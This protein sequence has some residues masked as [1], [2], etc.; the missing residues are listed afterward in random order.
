MIV[1]IIILFVSLM[2]VSIFTALATALQHY[3]IVRIEVDKRQE[4]KY[5]EVVARLSGDRRRAVSA[6]NTGKQI[7]LLI[8]GISFYALTFDP[9]CNLLG[10]V[11]LL[12]VILQIILSVAV[13]LLVAEIVPKVVAS[14]NPDIV[15][16]L[17]YGLAAVSYK[18][19]Y[20]SVRKG[21]I[22][23]D[24]PVGQDVMMIQNALSFS[25]VVLRE[26]MIPR[27]E[28]CAIEEGTSYEELLALFART[29][30]S[31]IIVYKESIDSITGY[32]HSKDL[33]RGKRPVCELIRKIDF[34][35]EETK[36]QDLLETLIKS[37][38][39]IAVVLDKF[40]GTAGIVTLEDLIEEIFG[41]ISDELDSD[42]LIEKKLENGDYIFSGRLE[43]KYLNREYDL[44]IPESEDYETLAGF[45]TYFNENIPAERDI[46]KYDN[47]VFKILKKTS[48][49]VE[50]VSLRI[51]EE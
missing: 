22:K 5:A 3:N 2:T 40:G 35:G 33:F 41:E 39:A 18:I 34:F 24:E 16:R 43:V 44:N 9:V 36:A 29:N 4:Y 51:V 48:N 31:R 11:V 1:T 27:T 19:F 10:D 8:F 49:R 30:Y 37:R 23:E 15:L 12:A 38:S 6:M 28:V 17:F 45:I 32:I 13:V 47:M 50:V 26:C 25:D 46:L 20:R 14:V 21:E 42:E 7:F